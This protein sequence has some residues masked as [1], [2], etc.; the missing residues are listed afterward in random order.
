M[1]SGESGGKRMNC[2]I[3]KSLLCWIYYTC[4]LFEF[5]RCVSD[6]RI[7]R[8]SA[9]NVITDYAACDSRLLMHLWGV[10]RRGFRDIPINHR[11][12]ESGRYQA[13]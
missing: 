1:Q 12:N 13:F 10:L 5:L 4:T 11:G 3:R 2:V 6:L 7:W 8:S 9:I